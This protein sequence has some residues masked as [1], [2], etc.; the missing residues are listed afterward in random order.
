MDHRIFDDLHQVVLR[1]SRSVF[2][3]SPLPVAPGNR[4]EF[5]VSFEHIPS[6]WNTQLPHVSVTGLQLT[7]AK[8]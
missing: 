3:S 7:A 8:E 4:R 2:S 5:E 1:E 6:S